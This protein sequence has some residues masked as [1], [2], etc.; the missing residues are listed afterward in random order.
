MQ[1]SEAPKFFV[2][3]R[4]TRAPREDVAAI[5]REF[6][7]FW[8]RRGGDDGDPSNSA[9]QRPRGLAWLA[10]RPLTANVRLRRLR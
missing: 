9:V 8:A 5:F 6:V 2:S 4:L 1:V 10:L 3:R 7:A